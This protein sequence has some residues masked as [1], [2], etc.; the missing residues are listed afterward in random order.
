MTEDSEIA[1]RLMEDT[2]AREDAPT[3]RLLVELP[4]LHLEVRGT[5][6]AVARALAVINLEELAR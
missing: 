3:A 4:D 6:D 2:H 1:I 5:F